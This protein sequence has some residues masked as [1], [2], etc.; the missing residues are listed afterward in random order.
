MSEQIS[1]SDTR[2]VY[3]YSCNCDWISKYCDEHHREVARVP[4][5]VLN[6]YRI[7]R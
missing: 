6:E 3:W 2:V 5:A 1:L 7:A 4:L